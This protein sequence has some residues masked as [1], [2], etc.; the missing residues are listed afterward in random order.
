LLLYY[1][2]QRCLALPE[3]ARTGVRDKSGK[4]NTRIWT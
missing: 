3:Y 1:V 2:S 4:N